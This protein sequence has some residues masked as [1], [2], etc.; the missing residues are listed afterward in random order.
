MR[1]AEKFV[2][3]DA[4]DDQFSGVSLQSLP[5]GLKIALAYTVY[6]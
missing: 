2:K 4:Q 1:K 5:F 6:C 3:Q